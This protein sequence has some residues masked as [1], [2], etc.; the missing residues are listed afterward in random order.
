M[1][2]TRENWYGLAGSCKVMMS[3]ITCENMVCEILRLDGGYMIP[4][5][6]PS[7]GVL[8]RMV[9]TQVWHDLLPL[10]RRVMI[11]SLGGLVRADCAATP[12]DRALAEADLEIHDSRPR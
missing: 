2:S 6:E 9:R 12:M 4:S 7:E 10:Q 1:M 3:T 5:T 8:T 11:R